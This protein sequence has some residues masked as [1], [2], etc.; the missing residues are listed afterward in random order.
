MSVNNPTCLVSGAHIQVK[1]LVKMAQTRSL[2]LGVGCGRPKSSCPFQDYRTYAPD[3]SNHGGLEAALTSSDPSCPPAS[4]R[5]SALAV[6]AGPRKSPSPPQGLLHG[7]PCNTGTAAAATADD[8]GRVSPAMLLRTPA[9]ET[10]VLQLL[11]IDAKHLVHLLQDLLLVRFFITV[12]TVWLGR[13]NLGVLGVHCESKMFGG[14]WERLESKMWDSCKS[15]L[16]QS[17]ML[18]SWQSL[19]F[20]GLRESCTSKMWDSKVSESWESKTFGKSSSIGSGERKTWLSITSLFCS[21]SC[22]ARSM[23]VALV[24]EAPPT[25]MTLK[26]EN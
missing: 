15:K 13:R 10:A 1:C 21:S 17:G 12:F 4:W 16:W 2:Y 23:A 3:T 25:K 19:M 22:W 14:L 7:Q 8:H 20:G 24:V 6:A 18:E 9:Q 26:L 5:A 11:R